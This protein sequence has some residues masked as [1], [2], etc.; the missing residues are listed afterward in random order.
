MLND[1][2]SILR[3]KNTYV[4]SAFL[5]LLFIVISGCSSK[6]VSHEQDVP[7]NIAIE[8]D[9]SDDVTREQDVDAISGIA[10][11]IIESNYG[12]PE[13]EDIIKEGV[14]YS[15]YWLS[16]QTPEKKKKLEELSYILSS[17]IINLNI[18]SLER[19][20]NQ[21]ENIEGKLDDE[22]RSGLEGLIDKEEG[23]AAEWQKHKSDFN[24]EI[25]K[26][27]G[28]FRE[29]L[30]TSEQKEQIILMNREVYTE[31]QPIMR[32]RME[33]RIKGMF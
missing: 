8:Q 30:E 32:Q 23:F 19:M 31:N 16:K 1:V 27:V 14:E 7:D 22:K 24:K 3:Y 25:L 17:L 9:V 15:R 6:N 10:F 20:T 11:L 33:A 29:K 4:F 26:R 2:T 5:F 28:E 18:E 21:S 12:Y 13:N